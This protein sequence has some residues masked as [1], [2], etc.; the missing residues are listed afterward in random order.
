[1]RAYVCVWANNG[2][3]SSQ[4]KDELQSDPMRKGPFPH[5]RDVNTVKIRCSVVRCCG[6]TRYNEIRENNEEKK[7]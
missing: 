5:V 4:S 3:E 7:K 2:K 1:M 6:F